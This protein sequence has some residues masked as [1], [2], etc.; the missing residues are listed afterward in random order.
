MRLYISLESLC[1]KAGQALLSKYCGKKKIIV[2]KLQTTRNVL[3]GD[4]GGKSPGTKAVEGLSPKDRWLLEGAVLAFEMK[5]NV[6]ALIRAG[7]GLSETGWS[8]IESPV[9]VKREDE[10]EDED[11]DVIPLEPGLL[12]DLEEKSSVSVSLSYGMP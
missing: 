5:S 7:A 1:A 11:D 9:V 2:E 8:I 4:H 6:I 3:A 12:A 10:D